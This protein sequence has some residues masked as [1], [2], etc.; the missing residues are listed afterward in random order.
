MVSAKVSVCLDQ[1]DVVQEPQQEEGIEQLFFQFQMTSLFRQTNSELVPLNSL[2]KTL[3]EFDSREG[4]VVDA[5]LMHFAYGIT[6][7]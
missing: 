7:Q 4:Y 1:S 6:I 3:Q 5:R 2:Y